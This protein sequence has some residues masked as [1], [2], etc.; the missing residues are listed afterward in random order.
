VLRSKPPLPLEY[1]YFFARN[2]DFRAHAI[3]N[4]TGTSGRQRVPVSCFDNYQLIV[5]ARSAAQRF[6]KIARP[7]ITAIKRHDEESRTLAA[8][9]DALLPKHASI[10]RAQSRAPRR[11]SSLSRSRRTFARPSARAQS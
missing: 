3:T 4:M 1:T 5:P 7:I 9:R 10:R 8:I 11:S 2:D 6:G